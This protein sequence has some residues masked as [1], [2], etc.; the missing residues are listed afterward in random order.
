[1]RAA[2]AHGIEEGTHVEAHLCGQLDLHV[3]ARR[4]QCL[5]GGGLPHPTQEAVGQH[6]PLLLGRLVGDVLG[7]G[8]RVL[9][10]EQPEAIGTDRHAVAGGHLEPV[11]CHLSVH[12][13]GAT[14]D[15]VAGVM[16]TVDVLDQ[17]THDV[18]D[19]QLVTVL[20][21]QASQDRFGAPAPHAHG[22]RELQ[23]VDD[24]RIDWLVRR[25]RRSVH[26]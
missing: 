23:D 7:V 11:R 19:P 26:S 20:V 17:A 18:S 2:V 16:E 9:V 22:V 15:V 10:A 12:R 14:T 6:L 21:L 5:D 25:R 8:G 13:L 3:G 24:I 1:L 4:D